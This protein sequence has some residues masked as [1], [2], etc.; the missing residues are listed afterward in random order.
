MKNKYLW[1]IAIITQPFAMFQS[2]SQEQKK[3]T[4]L[5][6]D[7]ISY[8]QNLLFQ[9]AQPFSKLVLSKLWNE[10]DNISRLEMDI[11]RINLHLNYNIKQIEYYARDSAS[12]YT[13]KH[14]GVADYQ[15]YGGRVARFNLSDKLTLDYSAFLSAQYAFL[16]AE[17]QIVVGNNLLFQ[18]PVSNK[19]RLQSWGQYMSRGKSKDPIFKSRTLFPTTNFGAGVQY[20]YNDQ[21]KIKVGLEYQ[22][23]RFEKAWKPNTGG[24]VLFKF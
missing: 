20:D 1:I 24:K 9:P 13:P 14:P 22:Y 12:V 5:I 8:K 4:I 17:K 2:M 15:N 6:P 21:T 11:E 23:D 10:E 19:L 16:T 18:Y 3:D 7:S